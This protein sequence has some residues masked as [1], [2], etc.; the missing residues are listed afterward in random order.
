MTTADAMGQQQALQLGQAVLEA[1]NA[2]DWPRF[3]EAG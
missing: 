1:F 2:A 3:D